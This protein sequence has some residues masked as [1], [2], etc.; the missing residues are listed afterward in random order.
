MHSGALSQVTSDSPVII[1][2]TRICWEAFRTATKSGG[3]H[4]TCPPSVLAPR[5][6]GPGAG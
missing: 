5:A 4:L 1:S 3:L 2:S 6:A